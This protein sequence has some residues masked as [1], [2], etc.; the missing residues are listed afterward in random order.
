MLTPGMTRARVSAT[1]SKVLWLSLRTM[2]IQLPPRPDPG[3]ALRGLSTVSVGIA[4]LCAA[5]GR[6][7]LE[8]ARDP[9][10]HVV[11]ARL[12]ARG[13][14][15]RPDRDA[16]EPALERPGVLVG[17]H[18]HSLSVD[19]DEQPAVV[20]VVRP[21]EVEGAEAEDVGLVDP[22]DPADVLAHREE[23]PLPARQVLAELVLALEREDRELVLGPAPG[24]E[25]GGQEHPLA[26]ALRR[27][28]QQA[29]GREDLDVA[30]DHRGS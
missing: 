27:A 19:E 28:A 18:S 16:G 30:A 14:P 24:A 1:W 3:S 12:R 7:A 21:L 11:E 2:T 17:D 5:T 8:R 10:D 29:R 22:L 20:L 4:E 15:P 25:V 6:P 13:G 26:H 9:D 23:T